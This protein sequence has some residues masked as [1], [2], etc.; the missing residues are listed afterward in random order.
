[1]RRRAV[2]SPESKNST[3]RAPS[4]P[5]RVLAAIEPRRGRPGE[6]VVVTLHLVRLMHPNS[7][8]PPCRGHA[9][10]AFDQKETSREVWRADS[11]AA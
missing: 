11:A 8:T 10:T 5:P 6:E 4:L 2:P 3:F 9:V 7:G 1:M